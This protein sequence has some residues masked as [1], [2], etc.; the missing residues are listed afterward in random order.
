MLYYD[1][2]EPDRFSALR[3]PIWIILHFILH[4]SMLLVEEGST[5]FVLWFLANKEMDGFIQTFN[6]APPAM[7]N[8]SSGMILDG[9]AFALYANKSLNTFKKRF[10]SKYPFPDFSAEL[11]KISISTNTTLLN[12]GANSNIATGGVKDLLI[13]LFSWIFKNFGIGAH[14]S[15]AASSSYTSA[16]STLNKTK[17]ANT[18]HHS[19][20]TRR[21]KGDAAHS[22]LSQEEEVIQIDSIFDTAFVYFFTAAGIFLVVLGL[23]YALGKKHKYV[24]L[25]DNFPSVFQSLTLPQKDPYQIT[26]LSPFV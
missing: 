20:L 24:I 21:A 26:L 11:Y 6:N 23:M 1:Q 17:S 15:D 7:F 10:R 4:I 9:Q 18:T 2:I 3:L 8:V 22:L 12:S 19:D 5:Q 25:P 13:K 14:A 16:S